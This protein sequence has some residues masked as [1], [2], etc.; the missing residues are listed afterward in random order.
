MQNR[1]SRATVPDQR[2]RSLA[3]GAG[4]LVTMPASWR[5][6]IVDTVL[7]P[8]HAQA[9]GFTFSLPTLRSASSESRI[10]SGAGAVEALS[11][12]FFS[13]CFSVPGIEVECSAVADIGGG[14]F[15]DV[16]TAT[17]TTTAGNVFT[18]ELLTPAIN[19]APVGSINEVT[20]TCEA[21]GVT[22]VVTIGALELTG[23]IAGAVNPAPTCL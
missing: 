17:T 1:H 21:L 11:R 10:P 23:A 2:R 5:K 14:V 20:I 18:V 22:S 6:P 19:I 9:S 4:L 7:L 16:G 13:G 3:I 15:I 12:M 8:A